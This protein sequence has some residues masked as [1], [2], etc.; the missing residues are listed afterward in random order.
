MSKMKPKRC[1]REKLMHIKMNYLQLFKQQ[2]FL[3]SR[4]I[5]LIKVIDATSMTKFYIA[6]LCEKLQKIVLIV[7]LNQHLI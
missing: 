2:I 5:S 6:C 4:E 1:S 3:N 7:K